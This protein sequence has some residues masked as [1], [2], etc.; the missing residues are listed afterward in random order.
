LANVREALLQ[1]QRTLDMATIN[2]SN[3]ALQNRD[4]INSLAQRGIISSGVVAKN[5]V[6]MN[7]EKAADKVVSV[8]GY[9]RRT[10]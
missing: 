8:D 6:G 7:N 4:F 2:A 3:N 10:A 5:V 9:G 1:H